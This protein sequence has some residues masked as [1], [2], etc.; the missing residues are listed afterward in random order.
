M[1]KV[2]ASINMT[3]DGY[4]DHTEGIADE[5]LHDH[6]RDLLNDSGVILYGRKTYELMEFWPTLLK[7]PSGERSMDEFAV[8]IDKIEKIVFSRTLKTI[9]WKTTRLATRSLQEEIEALKQQPGKDILLGSP[10]MIVGATNLAL[11][12]EYQLCVH[13]FIVGKGLQLFKGIK[14]KVALSLLR[15]K[16]FGSGVVAFY[17]KTGRS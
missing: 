2:I 11:V 13:P 1:R 10:S 4:C 7:N 14:D 12:D 3:L 6:F 9:E 16:T 15:T 8:A 5:E 17:Y